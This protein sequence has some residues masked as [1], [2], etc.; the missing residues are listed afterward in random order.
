MTVQ[1]GSS[2]AP[3]EPR[4]AVDDTQASTP[5]RSRLL[6]AQESPEDE[7]LEQTIRPRALDEYIGQSALKE[8]LRISLEAARGRN[9][10]LEHTLFY[11]P[12]GLGKTT[13]AMA[14]AH[15]MGAGILITS[16]PALERPRDVIGLLMSLEPGQTLFI[17]EIHRLNKVAEEILYPAMEDFMLDRTIGKGQAT[18][19]LRVPLPPFTL[20]GATTKAG[21]IAGPL[22]DRF[23]MAWRL[24]FYSPEELQ[25][26]LTRSAGILGIALSPCGARAIALRA[27]GTPRIVNR[28]LR[29]VRDY[30]AVSRCDAIDKACAD[31]A[32]DLFE[33]DAL[34]LDPTD[35]QL[36]STMIQ[37]FDGGPVGLETLAAALGEDARTLEDVCEPYLLQA[38]LLHRTPRGR[39][40][41]AAARRH[42]GF[43][44]AQTPESPLV[45]QTRLWANAHDGYGSDKDN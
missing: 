39:M 1:F 24:Q 25:Q 30:A 23:G 33:I 34:G 41:T 37:G 38:G 6:R 8:T 28:L 40:A 42:L 16:A 13:L 9:E 20:M 3:Q 35:R 12:P 14:L 27:R 29:R 15:E 22:R 19:I 4:A 18:K 26:I 44:P 31:A 10:P 17:D 2:S 36:L 11:G 21:S 7:R 43:P 45:T 5:V 32:L